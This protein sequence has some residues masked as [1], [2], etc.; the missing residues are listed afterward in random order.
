MVAA[1]HLDRD[2]EPVN[3]PLV[4]GGI[5]AAVGVALAMPMGGPRTASRR[6]EQMLVGGPGRAGAPGRGD[7]GSS[8]L[9]RGRRGVGGPSLARLRGVSILAGIAVVLLVGG[10]PGI[11]GGILVA[12]TLPELLRRLEPAH[13]RRD[14]R[15]LARA[16]PLVADLLGACLAAGVPVERATAVVATAV[17][18]V[19]ED[20]L[21]VVSR[22]LALGEPTASA[23]LTL[24][25]LP[26][27]GGIART[28]AR[29]TRTG[30]PLAGLLAHA[31]V[32]LRTSATAEAMA[33]VRAASVRAVLPLGLCLLPAF[34]LLGIAPI[35]AGLLPGS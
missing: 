32:D 19:T 20:V 8:L 9:G 25:Q 33:Q 24:S 34:A 4:V 29:S 31:A 11:A 1:H 17:G 14:R 21:G 23:W 28:V 35:V 15:E 30:A 18:G 27:L 12:A 6:W 5:A 13:V 7:A 2:G 3:A 26:S 16:A 22:R 10:A